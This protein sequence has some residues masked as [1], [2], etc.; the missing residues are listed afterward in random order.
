M[1]MGN[2]PMIYIDADGRTWKI[3][4][5]IGDAIETAWE[6]FW[7]AANQFARWADDVGIP[8]AQVGYGINSQ[9][10]VQPVGN[11]NG[12]PLFSNEAQYEA[13]A[14]NAVGAINDARGDYFSQQSQN[15]IYDQQVNNRIMRIG[16][17]QGYPAS[18]NGGGRPWYSIYNWPALG[19][20]TLTMDAIYAGDYVSATG[21]FLTC[22]AEVFTFGYASTL[23]VG[24]KATTSAAKSSTKLLQ[25]FNSVE[26]LVGN[27]GK[28]QRLKGGLRQGTVQ[29]NAGDIFKGLAQQYGAK[30]QTV[31]RETFFNAGNIRVGLHNA[32]K[33]GGV[34]TIHI[35]N[36]G[37]LFKIRIT[38]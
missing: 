13:A 31:G 33:G 22:A 16:L 10:Q 24:T 29:G 2:S 26:S 34:P 23:N 12:Q 38:P 11:I 21:H 5:K 36:A 14:Q 19:S 1:A 35:N 32:A 4:E 17:Q 27:A 6:G 15:R 37:Q 25:R 20:S 3:F 9:G 28:L 30:V 7:L 18:S 8:D